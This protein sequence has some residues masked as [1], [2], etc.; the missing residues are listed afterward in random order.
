MG[1]QVGSEISNQMKNCKPEYPITYALGFPRQ[2]E[3][4][5]LKNIYKAKLIE[6]GVLPPDPPVEKDFFVGT[7]HKIYIYI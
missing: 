4:Q 7:Y 1:C 3:V 6:C 5:T 2:K